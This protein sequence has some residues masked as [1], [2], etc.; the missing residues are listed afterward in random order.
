MTGAWSSTVIVMAFSITSALAQDS[1]LEAD[2][3]CF[4]FSLDSSQAISACTE[5]IEQG[6]LTDEDLAFAY[7]N[8]ALG[9]RDLDQFD[10]ALADFAEAI[11]LSPADALHLTNRSTVYSALGQAGQALAD[12]DQ[13][14]DIDPYDPYALSVRCRVRTEMQ[15]YEGA[16]SDCDA[17]LVGNDMD[18]F[19]LAYR[20]HVLTKLGREDEALADGEA[21]VN[22]APDL[23]ESNFFRG[24]VHEALGDL[25]AALKDFRRALELSPQ[26]RE[27]RAKLAELSS[28]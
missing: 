26:Q 19:A 4:A 15:D 1:L 23:W 28:D 14:V 8:R 9:F 13:A 22:V 2:E 25:E 17:A 11:K 27:V 3:G 18:P 5:A 16:I 21:S 7:S 20:S 24:L 6:D 10:R 12:L